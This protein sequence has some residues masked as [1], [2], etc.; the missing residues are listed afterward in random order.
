MAA[1][2]PQIRSEL[3]RLKSDFDI[4]FARLRRD[5]EPDDPDYR[6]AREAY[7]HWRVAI[8]QYGVPLLD[9][10]DAA[11]ASGSLPHMGARVRRSPIEPLTAEQQADLRATFQ[12]IDQMG[13]M[14]R[15]IDD[16]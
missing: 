8:D 5:A 6:I 1:V 13:E 9:M 2:T 12:D 16:A 11:D 3:R 14:M 7:G 4:A 10:I 15:L